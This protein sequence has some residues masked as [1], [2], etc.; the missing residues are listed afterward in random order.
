MIA[1]SRCTSRATVSCSDRRPAPSTPLVALG[2]I[3][4]ERRLQRGVL[5]ERRD[6]HQL[7]ALALRLE[8]REGALAD[9][10]LFRLG[11]AHAIARVHQQHREDHR[12]DDGH[13]DERHAHRAGHQPRRPPHCAGTGSTNSTEAA[14]PGSIRTRMVVSP[15]RSCQ[16]VICWLPAG[17]PSISKL[18]SGVGH[19][20]P[21]VVEHDDRGGHVRMDVAEHLDDARLVEAHGARLAA[22]KAAEVERARARER[23]DVVVDRVVVREVH[24]GAHRHGDDARQEGLALLADRGAAR[25]DGARRRVLQVDDDVLHLGRRRQLRL[26][27]RT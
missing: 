17:R 22:R 1:A 5:R 27:H 16:A 7:I 3:G 18:P 11:G 8:T 20:E 15:R 13:G 14:R 12:Q 25:R 6:R 24:R 26:R 23:E 9:L 21:R 2:E 19:R 4:V 10:Q